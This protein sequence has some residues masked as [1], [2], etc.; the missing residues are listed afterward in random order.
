MPSSYELKQTLV[1]RV[2]RPLG[3]RRAR[4]LRGSFTLPTDRRAFV[5]LSVPRSGSNLFCHLLST[6]PGILCFHELFHRRKVY[7][8]KEHLNDY[9]LGTAKERNS[10]PLG[11]LERAFGAN[12]QKMATGFKLFPGHNETVLHY[13]LYR[14]DVQKILLIRKNALKVYSSHLI[15]QQSDHW[16][17]DQDKKRV[18]SRRRVHVD[19]SKFARYCAFNERFFDYLRGELERT[20]Q[21]YL[22][23]QFEDMGP[24]G[25]EAIRAAATELGCPVE[26]SLELK[27]PIQ[28]QNSPLLSE[29]IENI[30]EL[31]KRFE[32]TPFEKFLSD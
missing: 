25:F 3:A 27:M 2:L 30:S 32:G 31:K 11:F 18:G 16:A 23:L 24:P 5:V 21:N 13:C 20:G 29:R 28:R 9:D 26:D 6:V 12:R 10:D 8:G 17:S 14:P 7:V 4:R 15:A 22:S 1:E 19:T